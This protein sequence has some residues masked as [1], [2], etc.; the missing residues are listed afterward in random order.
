M[1]GTNWV[2]VT[3]PHLEDVSPELNDL[4]VE[5]VD[6]DAD[7]FDLVE[8]VNGDPERQA[9]LRVGDLLLLVTLRL[10]Q[11]Q[12]RLEEHATQV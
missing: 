1:K 9:D 11:F 5:W 8:V 2:G 3:R 12:N 10:N 4:V 7:V 6:D